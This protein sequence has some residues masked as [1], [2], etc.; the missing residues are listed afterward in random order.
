[1]DSDLERTRLLQRD[2]EWAAAASEGR[3][4]ELVLSYWT[5]DAVVLAPGMPAVIGKDALRR[6][7][8][9]SLQSPASEFAGHQRMSPFHL[10]G[11]SPTCSRA[12]LCQNGER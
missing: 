12:S 4:L 6:Y 8:Q 11:N 10:M 9:E 1:V 3:D 5:D 7:V 2:A